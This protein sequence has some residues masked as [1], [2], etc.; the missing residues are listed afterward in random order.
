MKS[1]DELK[2]IEQKSEEQRRMLKAYEILEEAFGKD[3]IPI[4]ILRD[5]VPE[6]E[7]EATKILHELSNGRLNINFRFGRPTRVGSQT[8]ELIVEAEDDTG[9]HPVTRFSGGE[10]MRINLALRLGISEVIARR[11]GYK[12]KIETR[13]STKVSAPLM[14]KVVRQQLRYSANSDRDSRRLLQYRILTK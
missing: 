8:T 14:K 10:R 7:E 5:L 3:G 6:V 1:K 11:S 12:G 13:S 9:I 4:S 2:N